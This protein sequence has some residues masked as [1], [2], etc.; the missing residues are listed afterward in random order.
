M[1]MKK[2]TLSNKNTQ[3][4]VF[5]VVATIGALVWWYLSIYAQR[6]EQVTILK[7]EYSTKQN[8]LNTIL[9][10]KPQLKRLR[11]EAR[12]NEGRLD[13]LKSIFPDQK[14]IPKLIRDITGVTRASGIITTKFIP[15]PDVVQEYYIENRYKIEIIGGYHQVANFFSYLSGLSLIINLEAVSIV[16][17]P[18]NDFEKKQYA[19]YGGQIQTVKAGFMMTTFS[20][21]K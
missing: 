18:K 4:C 8:R 14:E 11:I 17:N 15:L 9:A 16:P 12:A 2:V 10:M 6:M 1:N 21:K 13:S 5:I 7:T 3:I 20:S 19:E